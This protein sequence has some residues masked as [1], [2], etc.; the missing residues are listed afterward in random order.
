[1][2]VTPALAAALFAGR[3]ALATVFVVAGAAKLRDPNGMW[4]MLRGFGA[5]VRASDAAARVLPWLELG[6]GVLLLPAA[7]AGWAAIA[8]IGLLGAFTAAIAWNLARGRRPECR[9]FGQIGAGPVGVEAI[10]RNAVFAALAASVFVA[11]AVQVDAAAFTWGAPAFPY[12]VATIVAGLLLAQTYLLFE[13]L[14]QQ[15]R[16]LLRLE[17]LEFGARSPNEGAAHAADQGFGIGSRAPAFELPALDGD[18]RSLASLLAL[19]KRLLIVFVHPTCGPCRALVPQIAR[20]HGDLTATTT[21]VVLTEGS[22]EDNR[23]FVA[24]VPAS[25][26]LLQAGRTVAD[27]Y[28]A[29]GTPAAVM[30]DVDGTVGGTVV[31]GAERIAA[32]VENMRAAPLIPAVRGALGMGAPAPDF[33]AFTPNGETLR[34]AD[35]RGTD[36][37]LLFWS[38]QCGFCRRA[39]GDVVDWERSDGVRLIVVSSAP[40]D[41]LAARGFDGALVLD[42]GGRIAAV[43][44]ARGT[45]MAVRIGADGAVASGVVAGRDAIAMLL[46]GS[47]V[48]VS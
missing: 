33:V 2:T 48:A 43:F 34:M 18:V 36:V 38:P 14:R 40:D 25:A 22:V 32:L 35:F 47:P 31:K 42:A 46:E 9:C 26:V 28:R 30:I 29:F 20:W 10:G 44:G 15:G 3:L 12:L 8:A 1:M 7:S 27:D 13:V 11:P 24:G 41:E 16:I 17:D 21:V 37:V 39:A 5:G 6:V 4:S 19:G 23:T 45:P